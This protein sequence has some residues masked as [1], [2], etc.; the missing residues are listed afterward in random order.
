MDFHQFFEYSIEKKEDIYKFV[1][2]RS[3]I[4][5]NLLKKSANI[6]VKSCKNQK[7]DITIMLYDSVDM[8]SDK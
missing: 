2:D 7:H 3:K 8:F 1:H 4:L 6:K 5:K